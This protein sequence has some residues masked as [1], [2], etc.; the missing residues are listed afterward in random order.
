[1]D[2]I[3]YKKLPKGIEL[4]PFIRCFQGQPRHSFTKAA[5]STVGFLL[6][7]PAPGFLPHLCPR[8]RSTAQTLR[9]L[10]T[11]LDVEL[12]ILNFNY[13]AFPALSVRLE[14]HNGPL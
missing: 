3:W 4:L 2:P 8:S 1:M 5:N 9:Q 14:V 6:E 11:C 13:R 12:I 10:L 7:P